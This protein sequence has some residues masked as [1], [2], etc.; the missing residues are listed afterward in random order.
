M[1]TFNIEQT[2]S[3]CVVTWRYHDGSVFTGFILLAVLTIVVTLLTHLPLWGLAV[4]FVALAIHT[5]SGKTKIILNADGLTSIYTNLIRKREERI[6]LINI[7]CFKKKIRYNHGKLSSAHYTYLLRVIAQNDRRTNKSFGIP[8]KEDTEEELDALCNQLNVFLGALKAEA[9]GVL[10]KWELPKPMVFTLTSPPQHIEPPPKCRWH[11]QSDFDGFGFRFRADAKFSNLFLLIFGTFFWIGLVVFVLQIFGV[12][13]P[14]RQPQ[15]IAWGDMLIL[16]IPLVVIGLWLFGVM[17][18]AYL[19][20][21]SRSSWWFSLSEAEF[22]TVRFGL[23]RTTNYNLTDWNSLVVSLPDD[24]EVKPELIAEGDLNA[25]QT[26]Y[27]DCE[28][29]QVVFLD[30]AGERCMAIEKLRKPEALWLADVILRE[31]RAIR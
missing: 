6:D 19:K 21:F 18:N 27:N 8:A 2:D 10:A 17:L 5:W 20:L 15:G 11:Y 22:R 9:A 30:T 25:I 3:Q 1:S 23:V 4:F 28:L 12:L 14:Q 7:R 16:L 26:F 29:W 24:E 13:N 31:R